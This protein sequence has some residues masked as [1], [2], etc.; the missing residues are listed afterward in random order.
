MRLHPGMCGVLLAGV[1]ALLSTAEVNARTW[2]VALD[3]SGDFAVVS[4]ACQAAAS[5]D[6]IR[7]APGVYDENPTPIQVQN[8]GLTILGTG[9]R[10]DDTWLRLRF[11]FVTCDGVLLQNLRL[12]KAGGAA[13]FYGR[14][15]AT[16]RR[17]TFRACISSPDGWGPPVRCVQ[18]AHL[19]IEDCVFEGNQNVDPLEPQDGGAVSGLYVTIRNSLFVD[20]VADG[21]GGALYLGEGLGGSSIENCVF[22][23]NTARTGAA[24]EIYGQSM[25]SNCTLVAN[26]VTDPTGGAI[27]VWE[28]VSGEITHTIVAGTIGGYGAACPYG[29]SFRCCDFW[30]NDG[31]DGYGW[32]GISEFEGDFSADPLLCD[33]E[34]GDVGLV[35]GSPC[36]PGNH[37]GVECGLIGARGLG[38]GIVPVRE[39]TWG[40]LK[41]LYR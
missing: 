12:G 8:K 20:N 41:A 26:R 5:G 21:H 34:T 11:G 17:C 3:G 10:P 2:N 35:P 29:S 23:R 31:G 38:C 33:P 27:C 9:Q 28:Q 25:V 40:M 30:D 24:F 6:S 4:Q 7:I 16:V 15:E 19:L 39:T 22:F 36:L 37:G 18:G 13:V 1:L 32:C 14:G